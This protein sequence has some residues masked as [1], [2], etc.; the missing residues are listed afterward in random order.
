MASFPHGQTKENITD[1]HAHNSSV[2][3]IVV[4]ATIH[5]YYESYDV[6]TGVRIAATLGTFFSVMVILVFYKSKSKTEKALEDPNFTAAAIA[7]VEEEDRK[8]QVVLGTALQHQVYTRRIRCSL[9]NSNMLLTCVNSNGTRFSSIGG[10]YCS[11][12]EQ[13]DGEGKVPSQSHCSPHNTTS[14]LQKVFSKES[15]NVPRRASNITCSSSGSSYLEGRNA[16][17]VLD[18][19]IILTNKNSKRRQSSP[20]LGLCSTNTNPIDIKIIQPTPGGSPSGSDRAIS[21]HMLNNSPIKPHRSVAPLASI[22]SCNSSI[23]A[24]CP[25]SD[26]FSCSSDSVFNSKYEE[27]TDNEVDQFSTDSDNN[28]DESS[29]LTSSL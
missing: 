25:D 26:K 3:P 14:V 22:S 27:N 20:L 1:V 15:L 19:P 11:I 7:E 2:V 16:S 21:S 8:L 6:M 23:G 17:V 5:P 4:H 18:L 29:K 12:L 13:S 28:V 10:D 9:D 24:D